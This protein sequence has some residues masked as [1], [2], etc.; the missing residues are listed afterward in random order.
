MTVSPVAAAAPDSS[1][2]DI[3]AR[4]TL[5]RR[6]LGQRAFVFGAVGILI[7]LFLALAAP[8]ITAHH[9]DAQSL[10]TRRL[11]PIWHGWFYDNPKATWVH[12]L[13]TDKLGRDYFSRLLYGARISLLVGFVTAMCAGLIGTVLG[14]S[15]G[16]FGGRVDS[17]VSLIITTRLSI[18]VV[19]VALAAVGMFGG[20]LTVVIV[21]L[22]LMLWD[23]Y[24]IVLRTATRQIRSRTFIDAAQAAGASP[25]NIIASEVLINIV[26]LFIV[27]GTIEMANAILFEAALSFLGMGVQP[28][29]VSWGL[30]IAD[31]RQD[32]FF[33]PYY[34][35]IPGLALC[36]LVLC[37]NLMGD[38][39][40]D[41]IVPKSRF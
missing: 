29:D 13:G 26:G 2:D 20:S 35:T 32:I 38:G 15:A 10:M 21:V 7:I 33:A 8:L 23:R 9:P 19:L 1:L 12:P 37:I 27:V 11:P 40:R 6:L 16:Y 14:V 34:V 3:M 30:M 5:W 22:S 4:S 17:I 39:I 25:F 18:P 41:A 31:A 24:A 28:P 36:I